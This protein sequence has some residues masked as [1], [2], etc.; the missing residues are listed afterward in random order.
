MSL[1]KVNRETY[2]KE[3]ERYGLVEGSRPGAP[4]CP[5]GNRYAWVGF[6]NRKNEYVRFSRSV[7]K[8]LIEAKEDKF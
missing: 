4:R 5:Y 6:D 1:V 7:Y 8:E 2:D 3:P